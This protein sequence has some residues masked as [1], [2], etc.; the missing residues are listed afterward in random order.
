MTEVNV[1]TVPHTQYESKPVMFTFCNKTKEVFE[2]TKS[3]VGDA[4]YIVSIY[5]CVAGQAH[6]VNFAEYTELRYLRFELRHRRY[7]WGED[8]EGEAMREYCGDLLI[9]A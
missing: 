1:E 3:T 6:S 2:V 5:I 7:F 9:R 4:C 8:A